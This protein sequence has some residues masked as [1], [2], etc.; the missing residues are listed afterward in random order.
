[1][2]GA[3]LLYT[4]GW[5][6]IAMAPVPHPA[7]TQAS[8]ALLTTLF[9]GRTLSGVAIGFTCCVV[10]I[11]VSELAPVTLRG[12]LGTLFQLNVV[13][14]LLF[15]YLC[16]IF[17]VWRPMAWL[18]TFLAAGVT[19]LLLLL[20]ESPQWLLQRGRRADADR[21]LRSLRS[22]E[23]PVA[24]ILDSWEAQGD[25]TTSS[26]ASWLR[27]LQH[28][29]TLRP[30][31]V[32]VGLAVLQQF[33]GINSVIFYCG[34]IFAGVFSKATADAA[35]VGVQ[36]LHLLMTAVTIPLMD[37]AG[38]RP[39]LLSAGAGMAL[40]SFL[41]GLYYAL[42]GTDR[43]LPKVFAVAMVYGYMF[44]FALGM[45][46]IPWLIIG[47][48]FPPH[49]KG[50]CSSI[51]TAVNWGSSFV[52]TKTM[53][54]VTAAVGFAGLFWMY[55]AVL[56]LGLVFIYFFVPETKGRSFAEIQAAFEGRGGREYVAVATHTDA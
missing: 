5:G 49:A 7:A 47:E 14:G 8:T 17:M 6:T 44:S 16:G 36:G 22:R 1:M 27:D 15:A 3:A 29:S 23:T 46:S 35:A 45:G 55:A 37:R 13:A 24:A 54:N 12:A 48:I 28:P 19:L 30:L 4:L 50:L 20:P 53:V 38:R 18:I 41:Y 39:L 51:A 2:L 33:S 26:D 32:G 10:N 42:E 43:A 9:L 21:A 11:Y 34:E 40:C 25:A 31:L 52:V 56:L